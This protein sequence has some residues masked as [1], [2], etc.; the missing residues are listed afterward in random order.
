M[1][2]RDRLEEAI[3]EV[4]TLLPALVR[5]LEREVSEARQTAKGNVSRFHQAL[6]ELAECER[7]ISQYEAEREELPTAAYAAGLDEDFEREDELKERYRNLKPAIDTLKESR[8]S[9]RAEIDALCPKPTKGI[10]GGHPLDC[11]DFQ[12]QNVADVNADAAQLMEGLRERLTKAG[13]QPF[14]KRMEHLVVEQQE[15]Q[16]QISYDAGGYKRGHSEVV[17]RL[18]AG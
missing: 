12:E 2:D 18:R 4:E 6:R 1:V 7:R 5:D 17:E 3:S 9:L 14:S 13:A 11:V 15:R 10:P 16:R 8:E